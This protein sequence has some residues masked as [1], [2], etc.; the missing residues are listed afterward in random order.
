MTTNLDGSYAISGR[1][2]LGYTSSASGADQISYT[3]ED[4]NGGVTTGYIDLTLQAYVSG[5][6][7]ISSITGG[8]PATV[9]AYGV[10]GFTY[11]TQRS[12][13]LSQFVWVN[14]ATNTAATNGVIN[15][16]D[17]YGDLGGNPP[18]Q[19][20]YRLLWHP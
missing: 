18:A 6:N 15:V 2:F 4:G 20:Y 5:T 7:S 12:T 3:I 13:N 8:N 17:A 14:V 19:A 16:T 11:I 9:T 1:A 10:P